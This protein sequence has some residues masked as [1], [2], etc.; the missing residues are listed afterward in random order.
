[1]D[2]SSLVV[3]KARE[4]AAAGQHAAVIEYLGARQGSEL[5]NSPSL[6]LLFGTAQARLGRHEEGLRWVDLA[7]DQARKRQEQAVERHALNARGAVAL[8]TGRIDQAADC[9]TQALMVA[10]RDGDH[11]TTGRCSNNLGIISNL[12]GRHA[13]A[14]GSWEIAGAA[15]ER[16]GL[17]R[18]GAACPHNP[19]IADRGPGGFPQPLGAA[20]PA[21]APAGDDGGP[22]PPR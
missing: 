5:A 6:A 3:D 17:R 20:D 9:F 21:A 10:S 14:I 11:A 19:A 2:T 12:R 8:V 7:L 4:L 13:E 1:M 15:F 18:G 16:A 22:T